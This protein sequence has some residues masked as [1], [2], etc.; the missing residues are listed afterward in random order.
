MATP[1]ETGESDV[2]LGHTC[3]FGRSFLNNFELSKSHCGLEKP[4]N[5]KHILF[6]N[7]TFFLAGRAKIVFRFVF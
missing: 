5:G 2:R 6:E 1:Q 4:G 3:G 7:L